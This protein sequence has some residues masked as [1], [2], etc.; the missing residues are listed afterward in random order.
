M[1]K[2]ILRHEIASKTI[3]LCH[4]FNRDYVRA[5]HVNMQLHCLNS[6]NHSALL[7]Y[8]YYTEESFMIPVPDKLWFWKKDLMDKRIF[9]MKYR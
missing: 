5:I 9:C 6:I 8:C 1:I 4:V 7:Q 2:N 3:L